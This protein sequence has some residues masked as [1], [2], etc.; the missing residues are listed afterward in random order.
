MKAKHKADTMVQARR[1]AP[2]CLCGAR[3]ALTYLQALTAEMDGVRQAEESECLRRLRVAARR[4]RSALPL[5][6]VCLSR[7]TCDRWRKQLRRLTRA[8]EAAR[9]TDVQL[10]FVQQVSETGASDVERAGMERVLLRLQQRR[11]TLQ[12]LVV[13]ALDRFVA[14]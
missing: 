12:E 6:T 3:T 8:T 9:D 13:E 5:F 11:R 7:K 2:F 14:S 4:L 10:T 1:L